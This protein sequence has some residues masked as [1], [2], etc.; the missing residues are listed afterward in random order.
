MGIISSFT[1]V[2]VDGYFAGPNGEI[3]WFKS[4]D[5]EDVAFSA[6]ASGSSGALVFGHTTYDMMAAYWPTP[7]AA[8]DNPAVAK[9]MNTTP[10]I[11]FSKTM[12]PVKD[13][14]VWRNTRVIREITRDAILMLKAETGGDWVILG[15]G[16]IVQQ[17]ARLGLIDEYQL[18]V[19]PVI[20]GTGKYLFRDVNRMSL[21]LLETKT[22][23]NG[24]VFLRYKPV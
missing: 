22:F 14:P 5:E 13:G 15:S 2:S 7:E 10:K 21:E 17:F 12:K 9:A 19:N 4:Q 18:M 23:R 8:R 3:D 1:H 11:V 16:S 6:R 24:R 20:L